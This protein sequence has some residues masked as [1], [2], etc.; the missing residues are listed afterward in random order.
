MVPIFAE[1]GSAR[2]VNEAKS[3]VTLTSTL[4][5]GTGI[6]LRES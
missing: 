4:T 6:Y 3:L 5:T 1:I 2:L